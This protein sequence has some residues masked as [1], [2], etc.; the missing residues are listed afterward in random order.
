MYLMA[1]TR[2]SPE[3]DAALQAS[4]PRPLYE[5]V[6]G[7][8]IR[9]GEIVEIPDVEAE[10]TNE[11]NLHK[12]ARLRGF[13][14]LLFVPLLRD[15]T[16]IGIISVTRRETGTFAPHHVQLL[17]TFADQAV[18]AIGNVQLFDEVQAKTRDLTESLQQQTATSEVLQ[19]ISSSPGSLAPVFDKML[20]NA[21]R[22]CGAEFGSMIL[23]E[24]GE[25]R[26]AALYNVPQPLAEAR[27]NTLIQPHPQGPMVAAIR[28]KQAVQIADL[29]TTAPYLERSPHVTELAD[30]GGA[31]T[32]VVLPMLREDEV[33]GAITIYRQEILP[34]TDKQVE[35]LNN[36]AKQV[37]IAIENARL[38]NELQ[39]T[40][41]RLERIAAAADRHRRSAQGHQPLGVRFATRAGHTCRVGCATV[42]GR[43]GNHPSAEK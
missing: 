19:I 22:V 31:R 39:A 15:G 41:Q 4:F 32:A 11:P 27:V 10:W 26:Q 13:R 12:V 16:T 37:V 7:E 30:L 25:L 36:F 1:F 43:P 21:T 28:T 23:I 18:I 5:A 9:N 40:H 35:I 42:R 33:I 29:R 17:Q 38:L 14:S 6:W 3:A 24:E 2:T 8:R 34:F 20:E